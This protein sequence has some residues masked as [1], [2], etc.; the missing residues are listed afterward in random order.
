MFLVP[1]LVS[2]LAAVLLLSP[3]ARSFV[4]DCGR[5]L[6]QMLFGHMARSGLVLGAFNFPEGTRFYFCSSDDFAAAKSV[7]AL[8]NA[9]PAVATAASHGYVDNDE[10]LLTSG[11]EDAT[12]ALYRVDQQDT[13][14]FHVLGLNATSTRFFPAGSGIGEAQKVGTWV[15][16]PQVIGI[17]TSGGDPRF[18]EVQLLASRNSIRIPTGFNAS[19]TV[20]QLA[21]DPDDAN[22]LEMVDISRALTP[23][24]FKMA[25]GG[26]GTTYGYGYMAVNEAPQMNANQVNQ[27]TATFAFLGRQISY[28]T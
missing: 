9:N 3:R 17:Q 8:T 27:V 18:T 25:L 28:G 15:Q 24:A 4:F 16:I 22:W 10:I 6:A 23:V 19:N 1:L 11:W 14:T 2:A 5:A 7:T 12:S 20:L 13:N 21:H 26:G